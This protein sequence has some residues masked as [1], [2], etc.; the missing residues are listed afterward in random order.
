MKVSEVVVNVTLAVV[1][2]ALVHLH[3]NHVMHRDVRG[4]NLLLNANGAVKLV[5]YGLAR[6]VSLYHPN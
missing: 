2:Q 6:L 4:S 1:L 3:E 5:D